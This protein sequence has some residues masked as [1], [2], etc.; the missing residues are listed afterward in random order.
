MIDNKSI[1]KNY[2][3]PLLF[4][5]FNRPEKTVQVF[6]EIRRIKPLKLYIAADGPRE[7]NTDDV[8]NCQKVKDIINNIDW[9][10]KVSTLFREKNL[11]CKIAPSSAIDWFF[12]NVEYG[13][14]LEDDC[15]PSQSFFYFCQELLEKYKNDTRIMMVSGDNFQGNI[16]RGDSSYYFSKYSN[17]WG[18]ATWKRA[19]SYYD[20]KMESFPKFKSEK[21]IKDIFDNY[22]IQQYWLD[23]FEE[24]YC[25]KASNWWDYQ[26]SYTIMSQNGLCI[27]P[28]VNLISNIGLGSEASHTKK[29]RKKLFNLDRNEIDKIF[30][31]EF[32]ISCS[33]ADKL[34]FKKVYSNFFRIMVKKAL[35]KLGIVKK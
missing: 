14:I 27:V 13:I 30:H 19:W 35:K 26:W 25:G 3:I 7:K 28:N 24:T 22:F 32:M 23:K 5:N 17:T 8:K 2:N 11:G 18:W 6:N 1:N 9:E 15:V 33:I 29:S 20:V 21:K 10:C 31:P 16:K 4:L 34:L 12:Q